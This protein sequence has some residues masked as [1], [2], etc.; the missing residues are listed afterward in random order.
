MTAVSRLAFL[1]RFAAPDIVL[2]H[3]SLNPFLVDVKAAVF[4]R[5]SHA[6]DSVAPAHLIHDVFNFRQD[7]QIR[8]VVMVVLRPTVI[9]CTIRPEAS[10]HRANVEDSPVFVNP[11][12]F[13][14]WFRAKN[15]A[16][17]FRISASS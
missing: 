11:G 5:F 15:A 8:F 16:A 9:A 17:F 6:L 7:D 12:V 10:A 2:F 13:H 1:S 3:D 14:C 4:E